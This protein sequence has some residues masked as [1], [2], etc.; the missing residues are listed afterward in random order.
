M[1][2]RKA[3][4]MM[5]YTKGKNSLGQAAQSQKS[6]IHFLGKEPFGLLRTKLVPPA[7]PVLYVFEKEIRD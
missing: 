1:A 3:M 5:S 6:I 7:P 2:L 4:E